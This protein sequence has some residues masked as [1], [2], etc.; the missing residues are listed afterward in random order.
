[1]SL[2]VEESD[3]QALLARALQI[4]FT[5]ARATVVGF[6]SFDPDEPL[7]K[8]VV[9]EAHRVNLH[10]SR[11]LTQRAQAEGQSVW[12]QAGPSPGQSTSESLLGFTDAMCFPLRAESGVFGAIHVYKGEQCFNERDLRFFGILTSHLSD[13]L[14]LHRMPRTLEAENSRLPTHAPASDELI[15]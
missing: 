6:L 12:L 13:T 8:I 2:C 14:R 3:P 7:P 11:H 4:I 9:P 1:M 5:Q 15:R 10:L